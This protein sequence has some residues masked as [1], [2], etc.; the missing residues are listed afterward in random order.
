MLWFI[1]ERMTGGGEMP[2]TTERKIVRGGFRATVAL[3]ISIIALILAFMAFDR[4]GGKHDIDAEIRDLQTKIDEIKKETTKKVDDI[5]KET[6][7]ALERI[8][9]AVKRN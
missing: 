8:G 5:R 2:M 9:K 1:M 4:V 3:L 6:A 7:T